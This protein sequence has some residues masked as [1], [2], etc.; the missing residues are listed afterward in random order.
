[1]NVVN[2]SV[3]V[4]NVAVNVVVNVVFMNDDDIDDD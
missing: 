2:V 4:V 1:M 3:N